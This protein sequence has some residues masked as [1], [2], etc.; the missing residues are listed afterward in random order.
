[1]YSQN[2]FRRG[3]LCWYAGFQAFLCFKLSA[4]Q[5]FC[6][7]CSFKEC[8]KIEQMKNIAQ[9]DI[10]LLQLLLNLCSLWSDK[11]A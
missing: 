2:L 6:Q 8:N 7:R 10:I 3:S 5:M 1:M 11:P 9:R 4:L